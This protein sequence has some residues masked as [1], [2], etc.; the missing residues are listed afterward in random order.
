MRR[1]GSANWVKRL[2]GEEHEHSKGTG[3]RHD[4]PDWLVLAEVGSGDG[5]EL[6]LG[7][8]VILLTGDLVWSFDYFLIPSLLWGWLTWGVRYPIL[9][10]VGEKILE[11][12]ILEHHGII[13][14]EHAIHS[15]F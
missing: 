2:P 13:L 8:V 6:E 7:P 10:F 15:I 14:Q 9:C 11:N 1:I 5:W 12:I 4:F 3:K